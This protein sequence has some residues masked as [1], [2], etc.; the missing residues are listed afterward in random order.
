VQPF[1]TPHRS[2]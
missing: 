2:L 1:D